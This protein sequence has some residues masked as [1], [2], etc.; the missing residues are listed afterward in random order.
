MSSFGRTQVSGYRGRCEGWGVG[1]KERERGGQV[2]HL[3]NYCSLRLLLLQCQDE[4]SAGCLGDSYFPPPADQFHLHKCPMK[5]WAAKIIY[6][7]HRKCCWMRSAIQLFWARL[8]VL[9]IYLYTR[10]RPH[11][12]TLPQTHTQK[13]SHTHKCT[14]KYI[15]KCSQT[16]TQMHTHTHKWT[17]RHTQ[18][19]THRRTQV[20]T[21]THVCTHTGWWART[22]AQV[23]G[24]CHLPYLSCSAGK[25]SACNAG[26][27]RP[28]PGLGRS[29]GEGIG[30][31]LQYSWASLVAHLV[32]NQPAMRETW[33]WFLG[34]EDHLEKGKATLSSILDWRI[35]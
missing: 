28:I 35:P 22:G 26:D 31:P 24:D 15:H 32:K 29:A 1:N 14:H 10:T 33:V 16:Y 18:K 4:S 21:H 30:Y 19:C 17:Q 27:P 25:E 8:Y 7:S 2:K 13:C 20:L 11:P 34:W 6:P 23:R 9:N 3:E 5:L 12:H